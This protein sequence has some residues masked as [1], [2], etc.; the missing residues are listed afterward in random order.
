[1]APKMRAAAAVGGDVSVLRVLLVLYQASLSG[2]WFSLIVP[3]S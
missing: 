2:F 3:R 1:M